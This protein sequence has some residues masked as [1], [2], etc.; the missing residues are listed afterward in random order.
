MLMHFLEPRKFS[1]QEDFETQFS[2]LG[3]EA[4]VR[5]PGRTAVL[6]SQCTWQAS[7]G[8]ACTHIR[9]YS[10]LGG[11][12]REC[13]RHCTRLRMPL[14]C[15]PAPP[16]GTQVS[17]LH[18]LLEPHLLRRLKRD[19]LRQLPPK[20]EQIIRVEL[21]PLQVGGGC[22]Q[23][24]GSSNQAPVLQTLSHMKLASLHLSG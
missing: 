4:Q 22:T 23:G 18:S 10:C 13:R 3:H 12:A 19:V 8:Y 2:D 16:P 6:A 7:A 14:I 21:S 5:P 17:T 9:A 15:P 20:Q 11:A 1:S 24:C